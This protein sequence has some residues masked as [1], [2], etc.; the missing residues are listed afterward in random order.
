[1]AELN[2]RPFK[3]LLGCRLEAFERL[4]LPALRPLP[5][6]RMPIGLGRGLTAD[7]PNSP[8]GTGHAN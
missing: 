6:T 5:P 8:T 1:M 4:D 2:A 3:K 7:S